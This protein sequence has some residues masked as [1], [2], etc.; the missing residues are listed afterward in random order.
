MDDVRLNAEHPLA[1]DWAVEYPE[2]SPWLHHTTMPPDRVITFEPLPGGRAPRGGLFARR[3]LREATLR[4]TTLIAELERHCNAGYFSRSVEPDA[5]GV[6]AL[7]AHAGA[8]WQMWAEDGLLDPG[9]P[10][11]VLFTPVSWPE[12]W[13]AWWLVQDAAHDLIGTALIAQDLSWIFVPGYGRID[14]LARPEVR[15][16]LSNRHPEWLKPSMPA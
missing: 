11:P 8:T 13:T 1:R 7:W 5:D 9:G 12:P 16:E 3:D 15:A 6:E 2:L 14:I 4:Y 10:T